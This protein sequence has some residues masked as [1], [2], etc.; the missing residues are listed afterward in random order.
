M[1]QLE[2]MQNQVV[3]AKKFLQYSQ[4]PNLRMF[5]EYEV[6]ILMCAVT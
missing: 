4:L 5:P 3:I 2:G 1:E 6:R